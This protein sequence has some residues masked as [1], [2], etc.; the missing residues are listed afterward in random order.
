[1]PLSYIGHDPHAQLVDMAVDEAAGILITSA[2]LPGRGLPSADSGDVATPAN[3]QWNWEFVKWDLHQ[4]RMLDRWTLQSGEEQSISLSSAG[5]FVLYGSDRMTRL[6]QPRRQPEETFVRQDFGSYFGEVNPRDSHL[7][8]LVKLNG[9]PMVIDTERL[10]ESWR[11]EGYQLSEAD[12][13]RIATKDDRPVLGRWSPR[14]D[15]FYPIWGSGRITELRW[16]DRRLT[17]SRDLH[18]ADQRIDLRLRPR[19]GQS[20]TV[21][22]Q[23]NSIRIVSRWNVDAKVRS[24]GD[25]DLVYVAV[26]FPGSDGLVRLSRIRFPADGGVSRDQSEQTFGQRLVVLSDDPQPRVRSDVLTGAR[27]QSRTELGVRRAGPMPAVSMPVTRGGNVYV[28][29]QDQAGVW[30]DLGCCQVREIVAATP[31]SPCIKGGVLCAATGREQTGSGGNC[32]RP[33]LQAPAGRHVARWDSAVVHWPRVAS[34]C[35]PPTPVNRWGT[36]TNHVRSS[37]RPGILRWPK[38]WD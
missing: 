31:S 24:I 5:R 10:E 35:W 30:E 18:Q 27:E 7:M 33:P 1:M 13:F 9:V 25:D 15:R 26:R 19:D 14:G 8:M 28:V 36:W 2:R 21:R 17:V 6:Q 22:D 32:S 4:G 23:E 11:Q 12:F 16:Q 37:P 34:I 38:A 29:R 3:A 20:P